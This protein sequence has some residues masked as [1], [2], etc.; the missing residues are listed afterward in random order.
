MLCKEAGRKTLVFHP[1]GLHSEPLF[2]FLTRDFS[3]EGSYR[4]FSFYDFLPQSVI[5]SNEVTASNWSVIHT[6]VR[7]EGVKE[8]MTS[9]I[10]FSSHSR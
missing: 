3:R 7:L 10:Y 4:L 5:F 9:F 6:G 1:T 2:H 8:A